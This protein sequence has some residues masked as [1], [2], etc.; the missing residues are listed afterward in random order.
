M[1]IIPNNEESLNLKPTILCPQRY[2]R[3][4]YR[5]QEFKSILGKAIDNTPI[6]LLLRKRKRTKIELS[7]LTRTM[8][9]RISEMQLTIKSNGYETKTGRS[10]RNFA[11]K[12][13][14]AKK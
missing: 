13:R 14:S 6:I 5:Y 8:F 10:R 11:K 7:I 3:R 1:I 4:D 12:E 2:P 9:L